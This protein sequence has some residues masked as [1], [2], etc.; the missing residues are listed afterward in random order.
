VRYDESLI[1]PYT[2]AAL[3][4]VDW[5]ADRVGPAELTSIYIGGGT[6]TVALDSLAQILERVCQ[7]FRVLGSICI[8]TTPN[9][10]TA[11]TILRLRDMGTTGV[12]LGVQSFQNSSLAVLGRSHT[13][14]G[15]QRALK[16]LA[17]SGF[18][19]VNADLMFA[20][21]GQSTGEVVADLARAAEL[22][23]NQLTTYPLFT[24][25]Y[26]TVGEHLQLTDVRM[27]PLGVR[28]RQYRAIHRWCLEHG[29][30]RVSVWGFRRKGTQRYSS[31][32]RDGYIGVGPG[33]GSQFPQCFVLNTFDLD[34]WA[35]A[36]QAGE[37]TTVLHMPFTGQ[38]AGWWWLYWRLYDTC[39]PLGKLDTVLGADAYKARWL[40]GLA[41]LLGF[42][43][44]KGEVLE[45]TEPGAFWIHLAQNYLALD[46]VNRLWTVGQSE[47]SPEGVDL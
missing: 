29:F 24:F 18:D 3:A 35:E 27:P 22:G 10:V 16:L 2:Q 28:R 40:L 36:A 13:A 21:P 8:E 6:P 26:S 1:E 14:R 12:S 37:P 5:W 41:E 38:M 33:A 4:E 11:E 47:A 39:I 30:E 17:D 23:A 42:A 7:R 45:L 32:T 46:Y 25:P 44:K 9:D 15:S 20:L 34:A 31:V 43:V 19:T